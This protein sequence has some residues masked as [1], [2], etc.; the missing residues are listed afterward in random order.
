MVAYDCR[1][2]NAWHWR[3]NEARLKWQVRDA[4][5]SRNCSMQDTITHTVQSLLLT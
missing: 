3:Q 4:Q 1:Q 5:L 2:F